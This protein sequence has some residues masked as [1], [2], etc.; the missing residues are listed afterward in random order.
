MRGQSFVLSMLF[1]P[2]KST[3]IDI[4]KIKTDQICLL[5][6]EVHISN[7]KAPG[8]HSIVKHTGADGEGWLEGLSQKSQN[9][10]QE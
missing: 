5:C 7:C 8:G 6:K 10:Y 9:I 4:I 3:K 1:L 2:L